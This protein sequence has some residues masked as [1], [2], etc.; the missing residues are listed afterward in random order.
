MKKLYTNIK[1]N[2]TKRQILKSHLIIMERL[3]PLLLHGF[4]FVEAMSF[5][6]EQIE[7]KDK[8]YEKQFYALLNSGA[9]CYEVFKFLYYPRTILMQIF[10]AEKYGTLTET[11][12][13][14]Y[15]YYYNNRKLKRKLTKSIQYPIVLFIIFLL[16]II[17]LNITVMPQFDY[18]YQSMNLKTSYLQ[19]SIKTFI[20]HFP[21][22]FFII[23]FIILLTIEGV[24]RWLN[25]QPMTT[26]LRFIT[27]IPLLNKYAKLLFTYQVVNQFTLFFKNGI[28]MN[29]IVMIYVNQ[30]ESHF[31]NFI[32]QT[33]LK[34]I[35]EGETFPTILQ[36]LKCFDSN[37]IKYIKQGEQRDKLDIEL[38][39]Y[40]K[41]LIDHIESHTLRQ[42]NFIQPI[43]FSFMGI[44]IILVYLV[45][46]LPIFEMIQTIQS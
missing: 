34:N 32:G 23:F 5:I 33:L 24:K 19:L 46:M 16:L 17:T 22:I 15:D 40:S 30:H 42:I 45:M 26:Q 12:N 38:S 36:K 8:N 21:T 4:T 39:V 37:F 31:L 1:N 43:M 25:K 14:C 6:F 10:F 29:D 13:T 7:L 9:N 41:F 28:P 20:T 27:S 2:R 35:K 11:L 18:M 3:Q 44:L